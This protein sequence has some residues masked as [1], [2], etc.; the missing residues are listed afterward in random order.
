VLGEQPEPLPGTL[1]ERAA[2]DRHQ[3]HVARDPEQPRR[4]AATG[5]VPKPGAD[6]PRLRERLRGQIVGRVRIVAPAQQEPVHRFGVAFIEL[7]EGGRVLARG[8]QQP[9]VGSHVTDIARGPYCVTR[10]LRDAVKAV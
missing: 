10:S 9:G 7:A 2:A 8:G 6:E 1:L 3:Q 5:L 4:G